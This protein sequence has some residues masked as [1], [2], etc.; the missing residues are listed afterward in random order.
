MKRDPGSQEHVLGV[1]TSRDAATSQGRVNASAQPSVQQR[2]GRYALLYLL[3]VVY[4]SLVPLNFVDR[5]LHEALTAFSPP[6]WLPLGPGDRADWI[7]NLVLY[8][9][10]SFLALAASQAQQ[11]R[12][13]SFLRVAAVLLSLGLLAVSIEFLQ[14]F[15]PPRTVS[16]DDLVAEGAGIVLGGLAWVVAGNRFLSLAAAGLRDRFGGLRA[17]A[18]VFV[19]AYLT[20]SL[21]PFDVVVSRAELQSKLTSGFVGLWTAPIACPSTA[22]CFG[23]SLLE[24]GGGAL[25][26]L[27]WHWLRRPTTVASPLAAALLGLAFGVGVE[28]LQ[29]FFVSG[30]SQGA[31]ALA[32]GL[33]IALGYRFASEVPR[34][35]ASA[36]H[37]RGLRWWLAVGSVAYLVTLF[38]VNG[39]FRGSVGTVRE[40]LARL[41]EVQFL[42]FY[43][44]YFVPEQWA[45]LS[46]T[47]QVA[48]Y[49]PV[50]VLVALEGGRRHAQRQYLGW[51]AAMLAALLALVIETGKLFL[52]KRPD[53][54][55][56]LLALGASYL[57]YR[58]T[59][60]LISVA[61]IAR[62]DKRP[63]PVI[64]YKPSH[65]GAF[66][67]GTVLGTILLLAVA[68][69]LFRYPA[70]SVWLAAALGVYSVVLMRKP[71]AWLL[72]LPALL[73]VLDLGQ[74]TGWLFVDEFDLFVMVTIGLLTFAPRRDSSGQW[75]GSLK[76]LWLVWAAAAV[77][78]FVRGLVPMDSLSPNSFWGVHEHTNA[79]RGGRAVLWTLLLFALLPRWSN[80]RDR[81]LD[82]LA[83]GMTLGLAAVGL[84]VLWERV[85]FAGFWNFESDYR[86]VGALS[87][88]STAGAQLESFLAAAVPFAMLRVARGRDLRW[89]TLGL[90]ALALGA[91][92]VAATVTRTA[93]MGVLLS[94]GIFLIGLTRSTNK[95]QQPWWPVT[96]TALMLA[97]TVTLIAASGA[98]L[99]RF[100]TATNDFE[101]R[102]DHWH[103]VLAMMGADWESQLLG[104]GLGTFP[105]TFYWNAPADKRPS[106]FNFMREGKETYTRV[107]AGSGVY[108]DQ[109]VHA[110]PGARYT[111]KARI[112]SPSADTTLGVALCEKWLLYSRD[113][114]GVALRIQ[115]P[116]QW[117]TVSADIEP[118]GSGAGIW[119]FQP[120]VKLG[121]QGVSAH[122]P[123]DVTDVQLVDAADRNLVKNGNFALSGTHW[124][125]SADDHWPWNI[126]NLFIEVFFEQGWLGLVSFLLLLGY[127]LTRLT[128]HAW[129]GDKSG[130]ACLAAI[131]GF[132]VPALFD[133][134][135]DEPRMRLL[136]MLLLVLPMVVPSRTAAGRFEPGLGSV[137]SGRPLLT[138]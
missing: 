69:A 6:H 121:L 21:F 62:G 78:A 51:I 128:M 93:L 32:R 39:W 112:R 122:S 97:I 119:L 137:S 73:P 127:S 53:P 124:L 99:S 117:E 42:P 96:L 100:A 95:A 9:P 126:F 7:A 116:G 123:L 3:F 113:C 86:A 68:F 40:A 16:L 82:Q 65:L 54:T 131:L 133:S 11:S 106:L 60:Y 125:V 83:K 35:F 19:V 132:F 138:G 10:L 79:L 55:D 72:V 1:V 75:P 74:W 110:A 23:H 4:G 43:Y 91:Y 22:T 108:L 129:R 14:L 28:F 36:L 80:G 56:V 18:A 29:L 85:T 81:D 103:A 46:A 50:G 48:M 45:L 64:P 84:L 25:F 15:F 90:I 89:R 24:L 8:L 135:I 102:R 94:T 37:W 52:G 136:L 88:V 109:I 26:G 63:S 57:A 17:I 38:L 98:T 76:L 77:R 33:G 31:S 59:A 118:P 41:E 58:V 13:V 87:A 5:P 27:A 2:L 114:R 92:A 61:E 134:I 44:Y 120:T 34:I 30:V 111:V 115:H 12:A 107:G 104:T 70:G 105:A 47:V 130:S 20:L 66:G 101:A 49:A 71:T 67:P